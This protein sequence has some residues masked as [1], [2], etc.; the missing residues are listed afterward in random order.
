MKID[1]S[2]GKD[3]EPIHAE[4]LQSRET[5]PPAVPNEPRF[6]MA[7][8]FISGF[9]TIATQV[10]W[11][12]LLTMIVGSSTY[13]FS[14]VVALFLMGLSG[15]SFVIARKRRAARLRETVL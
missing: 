11:T 1:S 13:A 6:W 8:A 9:V 5:T 14:I 12:R 3:A 4:D 7:C 10:A 15:G 2:L